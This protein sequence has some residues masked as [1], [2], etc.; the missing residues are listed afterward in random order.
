LDTGLAYEVE[1]VSSLFGTE[2]KEEGMAAFL[3]KREPK[4]K[5]R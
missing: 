3:E 1:A 2:D 4:F 5:G